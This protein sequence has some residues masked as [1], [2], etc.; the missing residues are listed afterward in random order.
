[1]MSP[2]LQSI[3]E[4][5]GK[6]CII[7]PGVRAIILNSRNEVLLQHRSDLDCWGLPAGSVE[8]DETALE[9]LKREVLEE[10]ALEVISAEPMALYSGTSQRFTYPNGDR[11][12]CFS[13]AFVVREWKGEPQADGIEGSEVRFFP[14]SQLTEDIV[15]IHKQTLCDYERYD[16]T[17]FL[18]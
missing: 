12:L 9:A 1:M 7:L 17:F 6:Q 2:Y 4:R 13:V 5:V 15:P 18:A 8:L 16:G 10:T 14:L 11:V 3:R